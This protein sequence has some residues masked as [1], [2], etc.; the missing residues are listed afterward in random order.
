MEILEKPLNFIA[1]YLHI[2]FIA[3]RF[4]CLTCLFFSISCRKFTCRQYRVFPRSSASG[5]CFSRLFLFL[6][7]TFFFL[8]ICKNPH[9]TNTWHFRPSNA[10]TKKE[11]VEYYFIIIMCMVLCG[12]SLDIFAWIRTIWEILKFVLSLSLL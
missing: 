9:T 1:I 12:S 6:F 8:L 5:A 11:C 2:L 3:K 4:C 7:S 10:T